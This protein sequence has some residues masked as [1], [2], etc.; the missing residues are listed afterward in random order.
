MD[1]AT[2]EWIVFRVE[3]DGHLFRFVGWNKNTGEV[4]RWLHSEPRH[5]ASSFYRYSFDGC[6][7]V[8]DPAALAFVEEARRLA[9]AEVEQ[10]AAELEGREV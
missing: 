2:A 5:V 1:T 6:D 9:R 4:F 10:I 7:L 8:R 3:R